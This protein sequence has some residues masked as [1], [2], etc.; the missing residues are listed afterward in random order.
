MSVIQQTFKYKKIRICKKRK[1]IVR[2]EKEEK[3]KKRYE[4][5]NKTIAP[6]YT[7]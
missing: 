3:N 6:V 5:K 4:E 2:E 7:F 1:N